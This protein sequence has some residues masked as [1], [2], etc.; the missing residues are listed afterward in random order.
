MMYLLPLVV[1]GSGPANNDFYYVCIHDSLPSLHQQC[2]QH[3]TPV[4]VA[5]GG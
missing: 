2:E 4:R 5:V 3:I 1:S